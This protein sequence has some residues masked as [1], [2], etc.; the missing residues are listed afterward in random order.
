MSL[1][2]SETVKA[3][4]FSLQVC[5]TSYLR[6]HARVLPHHEGSGA[7][8][9]LSQMIV[10]ARRS[11]AQLQR[12]LA[13]IFT[14]PQ[15]AHTRPLMC[16]YIP[17]PHSCSTRIG[18]PSLSAALTGQLCSIWRCASKSLLLVLIYTNSASE[19]RAQH[20]HAGNS[21]CTDSAT[22]VERHPVSKGRWVSKWLSKGL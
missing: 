16:L 8:H 21:Q 13:D 15:G 9:E 19:A 22:H 3:L 1:L 5:V 6:K 2:R 20:T 4:T 17:A 12:S 11:P 14:L 18:R 7:A 10:R